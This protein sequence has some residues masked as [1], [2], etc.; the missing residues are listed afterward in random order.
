MIDLPRFAVTLRI[1]RVDKLKVTKAAMARSY[2]HDPASISFYENGQTRP[3]I[4]HVD[5]LAD[6]Y[7]LPRNLIRELV[8]YPPLQ[9]EQPSTRA[10]LVEVETQLARV[11]EELATAVSLVQA[12]RAQAA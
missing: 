5:A 1:Q 12:L 3:H 8:G 10:R 2:G 11:S 9:D 6:A 4:A 7:E